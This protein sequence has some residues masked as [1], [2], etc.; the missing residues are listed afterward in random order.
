M[1]NMILRTYQVEGI[2][3]IE[4]ML[5][6]RGSAYLAD[7][8][9]LGKTI[10]AIVIANDFYCNRIL[11][12]CPAGLRLNWEREFKKWSSRTDLDTNPIF[13]SKDFVEGVYCA[14]PYCVIV[15]YEL[16]S[17][18]G[19]IEVLRSKPWDLLI[20]DEAHYCKNRSTKRTRAC[21]GPL[22]EASE[23]K[24]LLSGTPCPN[25]IIDGFE[26]FNKLAPELFPDK[27]KFGFRYT[28]AKR[29]WFTGHWEFK[30]GKNLTELRALLQ[31]TC[32]V[33]RSKKAVLTELPDKIYS[34]IPIEVGVPEAH[35][36]VLSAGDLERIESGELAAASGE[37]ATARRGLGLL[38]VAPAVEY[39]KDVMHN[40][41]RLVVFAY[42]RDVIDFLSASLGEKYT[43][44][45]ISGDTSPR[46]RD[47]VV[48]TFQNNTEEKVILIGQIQAAGVGITLTAADICIFVEL[49]WV[50]ANMAQAIDRLH[51]IGQKN[52][53]EV[54]YLVA[55]DTMDEQIIESLRTKIESI[56]EVLRS[57]C[58]AKE[59]TIN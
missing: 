15:S 6:S 20:L 17:T 10:Q 23:Y 4:R 59:E 3:K 14:T 47:E 57:N 5:N 1:S 9:G 22:W 16:A 13:N 45:T 54:H 12:V 43:T 39:I 33:R 32:M 37:V 30:G 2:E 58:G 53:V 51:R 24:L 28:Q 48:Q 25:G 36:L 35:K 52:A 44:L 19:G 34:S 31:G 21:F 46:R 49:D 27:Y 40:K 41:D 26:A 55:K 50:P 8:M 38:K 29:N 7:E 42:H 56:N 18:A 11:V